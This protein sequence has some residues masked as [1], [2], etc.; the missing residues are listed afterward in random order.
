[1]TTFLYIILCLHASIFA[2]A[3]AIAALVLMWIMEMR[4]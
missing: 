1:M 4:K 2:I 3:I